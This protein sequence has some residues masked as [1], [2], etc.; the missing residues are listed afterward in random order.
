MGLS[1]AFLA[2]SSSI[3]A[4][5]LAL[6]ITNQSITEKKVETMC[7]MDAKKCEDGSFVGR[8]GE[9]C[10]FKECPEMINL[11]PSKKEGPVV[12]TMEY[13]PVCGQTKES[14]LSETEC[15]SN[16]EEKTYSNSCVAKSNL[17]EILHEGP[18]LEKEDYKEHEFVRIT[19]ETLLLSKV[20]LSE[21]TI[22]KQLN[23]AAKV[24]EIVNLIQKT[25]TEEERNEIFQ[26]EIIPLINKNRE[27]LMVSKKSKVENNQKIISEKSKEVFDK[28][29]YFIE[30]S[31][32]T[33]DKV[34]MTIAILENKELATE[35]INQNFLEMTN[36]LNDAKEYKTTAWINFN[37]I[38]LLENKEDVENAVKDAKENLMLSKESI[39]GVLESSKLIINEIKILIKK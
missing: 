26:K 2:L 31:Q 35:S 27:M 32:S 17:A 21:N 16:F 18:C 36:F 4:A 3:I 23:A 9:N 19:P 29:D 5:P 1:L 33:Y 34:E 24:K 20:P 37:M 12:C 10:D 6:T 14:C 25:K 11:I 38:V 15:Y 30:Q 22:E 8:M 7:P 39:K 13:F 28:F